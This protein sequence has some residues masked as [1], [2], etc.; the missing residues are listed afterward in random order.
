MF[1]TSHE[2]LL[3]SAQEYQHGLF[4]SIYA[5]VSQFFI[6]D[7]CLYITLKHMNNF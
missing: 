7:E 2:I 5:T 4:T 1:V 6:Q 3:F